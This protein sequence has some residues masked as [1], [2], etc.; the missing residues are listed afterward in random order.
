M[1]APPQG[2]PEEKKRFMHAYWGGGGS[3]PLAMFFGF[4]LILAGC[5]AGAFVSNAVFGAIDV[6]VVC[7]TVVIFL[8]PM[9]TLY[10]ITA[11]R[12]AARA[13]EEYKKEAARKEAETQRAIE[14]ARK[15]GA[16][17]RWKAEEPT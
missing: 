2:T 9:V 17:A 16:M 8:A 13:F 4:V 15:S 14:E 7:A 11:K 1:M 3:T 12:N 5:V 6:F 10:R